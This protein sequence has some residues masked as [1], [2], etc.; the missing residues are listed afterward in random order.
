MLLSTRMTAFSSVLGNMNLK[1]DSAN[2]FVSGLYSAL[3]SSIPYANAAS[4]GG[5][6]K[7]GRQAFIERFWK[8]H[9]QLTKKPEDNKKAT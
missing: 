9:E 1:F 2:E 3:F 4:G 6:A 7:T 8:W 5:V